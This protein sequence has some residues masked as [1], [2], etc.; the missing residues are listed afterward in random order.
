ML[1]R[2][3]LISLALIVVLSACTS[4]GIEQNVTPTTEATA[5]PPTEVPA[6]AAPP[7]TETTA[8]TAVPATDIPAPP[9]AVGPD[10]FAANVNPL[11]GLQVS[12]QTLLERRPLSVKIQIFPRNQRPPMGASL[13]DIVYDYYQNNGMT[14]FHAIFYG[15]NAEQVGPIRSGRLFDDNLVEM[16]KSILAFGGADERIFDRF[17][18][19][20][21][22]SRLVLE[23]SGNCPPMCRIDP[24]G[25]NY[26]VANTQELTNY[27]T[28]KGI[29]NERQNLNGMLFNSAALAGGQPVS[30]VMVRFSISAYNRWDYDAASGRFLRLQDTQEAGDMAGEIYSPLIDQ[31]TGQQIAADNVVVLLLPHRFAV[32]SKSTEIVDIE[33]SGSGT[34]YALRDGVIY[35]VAWNRPAKDSVLYLTLPD[36]TPYAFKPGVTWYEVVGQSSTVETLENNTYRFTFSMP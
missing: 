10:N 19:S 14:R 1:K 35:Q 8:P 25:F 24:S 5:L 21:Y 2:T 30:S 36:G 32:K 34:G 13:A 27:A 22:A 18:N 15:T 26:L 6:A 17:I 23:G 28:T 20:D 4:R 3:I 29:S 16:Y 11:T 12:D 7:A 31:M 9:V 33:V